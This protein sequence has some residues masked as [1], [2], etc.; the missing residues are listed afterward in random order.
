MYK[1]CKVCKR[2]YLISCLC[3]DCQAVWEEG[4]Y[5]CLRC[6]QPFGIIRENEFDEGNE[7][8]VLDV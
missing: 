3:D 4:E 6:G 1:F 2:R 8:D 7:L 5:L